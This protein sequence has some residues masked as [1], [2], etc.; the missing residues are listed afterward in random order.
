MVA[1]RCVATS[2]SLRLV[3][4]GAVERVLLADAG[5]LVA[6]FWQAACLDGAPDRAH[7]G[8]STVDGAWIHREKFAY[9]ARFRGRRAGHECVLRSISV[10]SP[11]CTRDSH[12]R[13]PAS[14]GSFAVPYALLLMFHGFSPL[15]DFRS[16]YPSQTHLESQEVELTG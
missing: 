8:K 4:A 1:S 15:A 9:R 6:Q 16:T 14:L 2:V 11:A 7:V 13:A 3:G 5:P 10:M 12:L